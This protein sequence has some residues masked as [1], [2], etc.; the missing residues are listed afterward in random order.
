MFNYADFFKNTRYPSYINEKYIELTS[1]TIKVFKLDKEQTKIDPLYNQAESRIYLNP[2][3][4]KAFHLDSR[5]Q[6]L[7]GPIP[8]SEQEEPL[9]VALNFNAMV[10]KI[11]ELKENNNGYENAEDIINIGDVILTNKFRLYEV[12]T[13]QPSS[14]FLFDFVGW[15]LQCRLGGLDKYVL[16]EEYTKLIKEKQKELGYNND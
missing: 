9:I 14:N 8:Y 5:W 13:A 2:F 7:L 1:P 11:K 12:G 3:D 6:Q 15:T 10:Q 4:I 16:P